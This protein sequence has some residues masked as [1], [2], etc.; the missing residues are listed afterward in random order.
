MTESCE[1]ESRSRAR[2]ELIPDRPGLS[3]LR[4][5][6]S[7]AGPRPFACTSQPLVPWAAR[8]VNSSVPITVRPHRHARSRIASKKVIFSVVFT[9]NF[10]VPTR[11]YFKPIQHFFVPICPKDFAYQLVGVNIEVKESGGFILRLLPVRACHDLAKKYIPIVTRNLCTLY[12]AN[13]ILCAGAC[14]GRCGIALH[15]QMFFTFRLLEIRNE[16]SE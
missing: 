9:I 14:F 1:S 12:Y 2:L 10:V 3:L 5:P 11:Q 8:P 4:T 15:F 13:N 6:G 16:E 7:D